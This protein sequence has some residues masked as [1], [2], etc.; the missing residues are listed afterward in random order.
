MNNYNLSNEVV[1]FL[2]SGARVD[3]FYVKDTDVDSTIE[4]VDS[5]PVA[6][7]QAIITVY[8]QQGGDVIKVYT[9]NQ[10]ASNIVVWSIDDTDFA[11]NKRLN[12]WVEAVNQNNELLFYG[13]FTL[14]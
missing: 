7:T 9:I 14:M 6:I 12:Y 10:A 1:N 8:F 13:S 4:F 2:S 3:F 5:P 11:T